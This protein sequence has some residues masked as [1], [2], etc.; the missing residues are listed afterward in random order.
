LMDRIAQQ[1]VRA[2]IVSARKLD[3]KHEI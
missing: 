2:Y 3:K 1:V